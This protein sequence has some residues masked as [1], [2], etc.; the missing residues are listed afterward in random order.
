MLSAGEDR[1][2]VDD[3]GDSS[4]SKRLK[5]AS[6]KVAEQN[7]AEKLP[8]MVINNDLFTFIAKCIQADP[9]KREFCLPPSMEN[10]GY[11]LSS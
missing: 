5:F 2:P 6:S 1:L 7:T 8:Q 11:E 3:T 10:Q 9:D 4:T